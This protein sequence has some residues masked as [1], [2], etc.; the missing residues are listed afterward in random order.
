MRGH[1]VIA[2]ALAA[3]SARADVTPEQAAQAKELFKRAQADVEAGRIDEACREFEA[4][5][6]LD[7]QIGT[8]LNLADCRE[9]QD[10]RVEAYALYERAIAL[11][12]KTADGRESYARQRMS[13]LDGKLVHVVVRVEHPLPGLQV[14]VGGAVLDRTAWGKARLAEAGTIVVD[15]RA[16]GRKPFHRQERAVGGGQVAIDVPDRKSVV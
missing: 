9:R 10:R 1:V 15:A 11:A 5:M 8:I 16:S 12:T 4:S 14:T 6:K 13:A 3:A 2:I 7:A